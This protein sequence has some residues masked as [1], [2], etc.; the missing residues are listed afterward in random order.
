M[1]SAA[2]GIKD[3]S[4]KVLECLA[5]E[6]FQRELVFLFKKWCWR[7]AVMG[8]WGRPVLAGRNWLSFPV[9]SG[10]A[11]APEVAIEHQPAAAEP[12]AADEGGRWRGGEG[13]VAPT[14][15]AGPKVYEPV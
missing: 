9:S 15:F 5:G 11:G 3:A 2:L 6:R 13:N 7:P 4:R 8:A 10:S 14:L 1:N 12:E